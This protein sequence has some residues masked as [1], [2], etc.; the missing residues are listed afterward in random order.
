MKITWLGHSAFRI[1]TGSSV[2]LID[3]FLGAFNGDIATATAGATHI[4]LTHGH[5]D[6]VGDT[7]SIAKSNNATVIAV[8]ELAAYLQKKGAPAAEYANTGG[9]ITTPDFDVTFV[10]A[11]HSSSTTGENG[12]TIYLGNPCGLVI[13]T[14]EG[15]TIYHMGDTDI[16]SDMALIAEIHKPDIGIVPIGD[17]FTMGP[18][19]AALA[20]TKFFNFS[21]ILPAHYKTF[22]PLV[23]TPQP[24]IEALGAAGSKVKALSSGESITV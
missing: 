19:V 5:D 1:E 20:C 23:Q 22:P 14:R 11:D 4:A 13:T 10:R 2:L 21:V 7:V 8:F 16:F 24:F 15:K 3:P 17:R 12:E 6:H 18:K 9:M